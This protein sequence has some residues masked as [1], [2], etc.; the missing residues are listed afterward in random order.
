MIWEL[1]KKF[2]K[3]HAWPFLL[4]VKTTKTQIGWEYETL[5]VGRDEQ[6]DI[7]ASSSLH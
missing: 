1:A 2:S 5:Q 3:L 4:E 6:I 7:G